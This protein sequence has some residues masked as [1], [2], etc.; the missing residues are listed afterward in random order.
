MESLA[1]SL[2][3]PNVKGLILRFSAENEVYFFIHF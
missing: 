2:S 3:A 1:V